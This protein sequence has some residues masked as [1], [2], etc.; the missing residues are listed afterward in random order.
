MEQ[1]SISSQSAIQLVFGNPNQVTSPTLGDALHSGQLALRTISTADEARLLSGGSPRD[2]LSNY[3]L[4]TEARGFCGAC[5]F[6]DEDVSTVKRINDVFAFKIFSP[7]AQTPELINKAYIYNRLD[8]AGISVPAF[9]VVNT[10][11]ELEAALSRIPDRS[12]LII[13]PGVGTGSLGVY[14]PADSDSAQLAAKAYGYLRLPDNLLN[15]RALPEHEIILMD[16]VHWDGDPV[17]VN[18]DGFV[19]GGNIKVLEIQEVL[20]IVEKP[21]FHDELMANPPISDRVVERLD[22]IRSTVDRAIKALRIENSVFHIELRLS[23]RST[24]PIDFNFRPGG[25][26][27]THTVYQRSGVDLRLANV[28]LSLEGDAAKIPA[29]VPKDIGCCIAGLHSNDVSTLNSGS[30]STLDSAL[31]SD[32]SCFAYRIAS[33]LSND[34][35]LLEPINAWIGMS[36]ATSGSA[37]AKIDKFSLDFGFS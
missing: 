13:K 34:F 22:E 8:Q 11:L 12:N 16:Y 15:L 5:A 3:T 25:G 14:R 4:K 37:K 23:A 35:S 20:K 27:T 9:Q 21:P 31:R 18:A 6:F 7:V 26:L 30:I 10:S 19:Q 29:G 28:L 32:A 36:G 1:M 17:E 24:F 33:V 2:I